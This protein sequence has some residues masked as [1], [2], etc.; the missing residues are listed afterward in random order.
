M[1]Q[2]D[3][4]FAPR[5][6]RGPEQT[7]V[8]LRAVCAASN[9]PLFCSAQCARPRTDLCFAPRSVR[10]LKQTSVLLH[11]VCAASNRPQFCSAQC[12]RPQTDLSFAPR[13]VRG[14]EQTSVLLRRCARP[15]QTSVLFCRCARPESST[16][17]APR[18]VRGLNQALDWLSRCARPE[19]STR[20]AQPLCADPACLKFRYAREGRYP[21]SGTNTKKAEPA[22][23]IAN[24]ALFYQLKPT[25]QKGGGCVVSNYITRSQPSV[26]P[27]ERSHRPLRG[28]G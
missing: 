19:S 2:T 28:C 5:S 23:R 17:L 24:P 10:G 14:L 1:T 9:R 27:P 12:A 3:L 4:S 26:R 11:A 7:S 25:H 6:V 15:K 18:S 21:R 20:L 22:M 8:L 13:S 16:R